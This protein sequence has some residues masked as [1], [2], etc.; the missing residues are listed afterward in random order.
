MKKTPAQKMER[1]VG[2]ISRGLRA[3]IVRE[4]DDLKK[5]VVDVLLG[6]ADAGEF[7]IRD[8]DVLCITE[9]VVG[10]AQGNYASK[11]QI[12]KDIK[13]KFGGETIGVIFPIFSRNRFAICL[14]GIARGAKKVVL[15]LNYPS[16]EVG[17]KLI[18]D[19]TF[20]ESGVDPY[21]DVLTK[22]QFEEKFY[23]PFP[24]TVLPP[25]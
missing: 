2:T 6:A 7:E 9:S 18:D 15:M 23:F 19:D 1:R 24:I 21:R 17:N 3:P 22:A 13:N 4:G 5:I 16:D 8:R 11:D 20:D 10:R 25:I 14:R 12:A